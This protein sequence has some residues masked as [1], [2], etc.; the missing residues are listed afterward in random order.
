MALPIPDFNKYGLRKLSSTSA[1]GAS[2][3]AVG[4]GPTAPTGGMPNPAANPQTIMAPPANL[5]TGQVGRPPSGQASGGT[6]DQ[7]FSGTPAPAQDSIFDVPAPTTPAPVPMTPPP[8]GPAPAPATPAPT[9]PQP[10]GPL[11]P[12]PGTPAPGGQ[13][14]IPGGW[15]P[16]PRSREFHSGPRGGGIPGRNG[17]GARPEPLPGPNPY[18]PGTREFRQYEAQKQAVMQRNFERGFSLEDMGK[19]DVHEQGQSAFSTLRFFDQ[20]GPAADTTWTYNLANGTRARTGTRDTAAHDRWEPIPPDILNSIAQFQSWSRTPEGRGWASRNGN[21]AYRGWLRMEALND[22]VWRGHW[23]PD[24]RGGYYADTRDGTFYYNQWGEQTGYDP[25]GTPTPGTPNPGTP[26][27]T[28]NPT[29]PVPTTPTPTTPAPGTP[30][31]T[32]APGPAPGVP[33]TPPNPNPTPIAPPTPGVI[34]GPGTGGIGGPP[35]PTPGVYGTGG[36]GVSF[37]Q[38]QAAGGWQGVNQTSVQ[39]LPMPNPSSLPPGGQ[40]STA[41]GTISR[42]PDGRLQLAAN[43]AGQVLASRLK[44]RVER[45]MGPWLFQGQPG[46]PKRTVR[47]GKYN[48]DFLRGRFVR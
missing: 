12:A 29:T 18:S 32:P 40:T 4:T 1:G 28:P 16:P 9:T 33:V 21:S 8:G 43:H 34:P 45:D 13:G 38:P 17:G 48:Y 39:P 3:L 46:A 23:T 5:N 35:V 20:Y 25:P 19:R 41:A 37:P 7:F 22:A 6:R 47:P 42:T 11:P 26:S 15:A 2:P 44:A 14:G 10:T 30:T 24:G 27:P 36:G 31:P